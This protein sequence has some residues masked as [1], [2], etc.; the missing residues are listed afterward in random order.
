MA[1][2]PA[3]PI[4]PLPL[5]PI[6]LPT[7]PK[8]TG[9]AVGLPNKIHA[10]TLANPDTFPGLLARFDSYLD[11]MAAIENQ[12][13]DHANNLVADTSSGTPP[14][15]PLAVD[16]VGDSIIQKLQRRLDVLSHFTARTKDHLDRAGRAF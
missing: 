10:A 14:E 8:V 12:A 9:V 6:P 11:K 1:D 15:A 4:T 16:D 7:A 3:N 5:S 2:L 13:I